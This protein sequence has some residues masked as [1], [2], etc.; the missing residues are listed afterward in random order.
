MAR[1]Y[2]SKEVIGDLEAIA[3]MFQHWLSWQKRSRDNEGLDTTPDSTFRWH[4]GGDVA[5]PPVWPTR[6]VI[7]NIVETL[8]RARV[9]LDPVEREKRARERIG[10]LVEVADERLDHRIHL[11]VV[12]NTT[13]VAFVVESYDP[14]EDPV[15]YVHTLE[16][17]RVLYQSLGEI[18]QSLD[19]GRSAEQTAK[20]RKPN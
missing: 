13:N 6:R 19:H 17:A 11:G 15:A 2:G 7:G 3:G 8:N 18:I 10:T 5:V 1:E 9:L 12:D 4:V 20:A 14:P 16:A